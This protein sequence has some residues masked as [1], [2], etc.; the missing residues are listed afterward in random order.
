MGQSNRRPTYSEP[1]LAG[2]IYTSPFSPSSLGFCLCLSLSLCCF[3]LLLFQSNSLRCYCFRVFYVVL[4]ILIMI[5][6]F[7][8]GTGVW[9]FGLYK[10]ML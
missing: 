8:K 5:K 3:C 4:L 1:Y 6:I 7:K 10:S 9:L 2:L